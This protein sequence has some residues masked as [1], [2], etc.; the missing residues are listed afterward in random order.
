MGGG[1]TGPV[2]LRGYTTTGDGLIAA[3][4]VLAVLVRNGHRASEITHVFDP[5]PQVLKN[6]RINGR[7][8]LAD[9]RVRRAIEEGERRLGDRGRLLVR[10]SGTEPLIR[11]MGEGEDERVVGEVVNSVVDTIAGL[12][13]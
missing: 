3:L 12:S 10:E 11:V 6:V 4:Q 9:E 7:A 8:P 2:V 13:G 5:L 1:Q